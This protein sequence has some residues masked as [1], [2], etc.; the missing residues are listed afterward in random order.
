MQPAAL[1]E[2]ATYAYGIGPWKRTILPEM[3]GILG[4][5]NE[6]IANAHAAGLK[7]HPYTFR[8]EPLFLAKDYGNDASAEGSWSLAGLPADSASCAASGVT[9]VRARFFDGERYADHPDLVFACEAGGFDT[10]PDRVLR[11][12]IWTVRLLAI[13]NEAPAGSDIVVAMGPE[14]SVDTSGGHVVLER[15]D[16]VRA[17][18]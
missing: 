13:D 14:L 10:R 1:A 8:D 12:G 3:D 6:L 4:T 15:A 7:V 18:P 17:M 2:I 11:G 9:H 16:F 5:A